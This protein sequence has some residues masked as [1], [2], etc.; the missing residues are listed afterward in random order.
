V[1]RDIGG[2]WEKDERNMLLK[3][4]E[5]FSGADTLAKVGSWFFLKPK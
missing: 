5:Y 3:R 2:K 4:D 1:C